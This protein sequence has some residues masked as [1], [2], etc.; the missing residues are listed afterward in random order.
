M[1]L[2]PPDCGAW[3]GGRSRARLHAPAAGSRRN[4]DGQANP[5]QHKRAPHGPRPETASEHEPERY[6]GH[7]L[8]GQSDA[9]D[10]RFVACPG[11]A[12]GRTE[13]RQPPAPLAPPAAHSA[14]TAHRPP[15]PPQPPGAGTPQTRRPTPRGAHSPKPGRGETGPP[16]PQ[17]NQ[18]EHGTG[19]GHAEAHGPRGTARPAPS[20]G[21]AR[22]AR[23]TTTRGGGGGGRRGSASGHTHKGHAGK[24]RRA[25][26]PS[27]RNAQTALNGVPASK[28]K[29]HPDR[30]ARHTQRRKRGAR[31]QKSGRH[32][33]WHQSKPPK[34]APSAAH[35]RPGH[36]TSQGGRSAP[37]NAPAS[38]LGS[39]RASPRGSHWRQASST[40]LAAPAPQATMH[41]GG[42]AV[43][44]RLQLR[45]LSNALTGEWRN[46]EA[47]EG[48]GSEPREPGR[49]R[50]QAGGLSEEPS[51]R[52]W[53]QGYHLA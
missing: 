38:R 44:K 21:T 6:G 33:T 2:P 25:A 3:E 7:A 14:R 42:N 48:Q 18:T 19:A 46:V 52:S 47:G 5:R 9:T 1:I 28:D 10:T 26:G 53:W 36:S 43:G 23:A 37:R 17:P 8:H 27:P 11:K 51:T 15:P 22:G 45:L 4:C 16:P 20:T 40:G 30:T 12:E 49:L 34:Q 24:T 35:T 39:L 31:R 32:D 29:G 41:Q 13:A 50:H